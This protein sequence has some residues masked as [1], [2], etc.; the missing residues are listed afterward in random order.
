MV[1][2]FECSQDDMARDSRFDGIDHRIQGIEKDIK[3]VVGQLP[4]LREDVIALRSASV[5]GW[6]RARLVILS[7]GAPAVIVGAFIALLA[8]TCGAL[9]QSFAHVKEEA[10]FRT[11]TDDRLVSIEALLRNSRATAEP[12]KVLREIAGLGVKETIPN[13]PAL[14]KVVERPVSEVDPQPSTLQKVAGNLRLVNEGTPEY[15]PTVLRFIQFAS[16][17]MSPG[18]PPMGSQASVFSGLHGAPVTMNGTTGQTVLLSDIDL[19]KDSSFIRC[20]IIFTEKPVRMQNVTFVDCV[21]EMPTTEIPSP[22]LKHAGKLLLAS[23][24]EKVLIESL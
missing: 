1:A 2:E 14:R 20:R 9:Y 21:F 16:T 24:L 7:F 22:Y 6:R 17:S 8:V 15:W 13:L 12:A 3:D 11:R 19:L 5:K 23:N 4:K 18:A 10:I